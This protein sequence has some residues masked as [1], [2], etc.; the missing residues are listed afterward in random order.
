MSQYTVIPSP[1]PY[2]YQAYFDNDYYIK[3]NSIK[4]SYCYDRIDPSTLYK[5]VN[6]YLINDLS[7]IVQ[8]YFYNLIIGYDSLFACGK[9]SDIYNGTAL[10]SHVFRYLV[11]T[12]EDFKDEY[13]KKANPRYCR[14]L[15]ESKYYKIVNG[16]KYEIYSRNKNNYLVYY[17]IK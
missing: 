11:E 9:T 8:N 1:D 13:I 17:S 6:T 4:I 14:H 3:N 5:I 15:I 10:K 2:Y 16:V 7:I 12:L